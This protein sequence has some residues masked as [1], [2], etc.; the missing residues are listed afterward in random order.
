M[1]TKTHYCGFSLDLY[2]TR[3]HR[4]EAPSSKA[5]ERPFVLRNMTDKIYNL[6]Y[7]YRFDKKGIQAIQLFIFKKK[8]SGKVTF[9][10]FI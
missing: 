9:T 5:H 6:S 4:N 8:N 2:E 10:S 3:K 7:S 1:K